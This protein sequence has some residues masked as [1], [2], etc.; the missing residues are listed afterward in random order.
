MTLASTTAQAGN[1][2]LFQVLLLLHIT[3]AV[4]G[5]GALVYRGLALDL[6]RRRG[7][8]PTAGV[9]DVYGQIS[10]IAEVLVYGVVVFGVAALA[11]SNHSSVFHRPWLPVAI[12]VYVVMLGVLHGM[13]RP[14]E[15]RYKELLLDLAQSP[16][17]APPNRPPELAQL[18][19]LSRRI[20]GG[21]GLFNVLLLA[22]LY[23][24]VFK[25]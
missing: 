22:A 11:A 10:G 2:V 5:F 20:G 4:G 7:P 3:C 8:A 21:M 17:V 18:D 24:M 1:S 9:L 19:R 13:V 12:G 15:K 6:A 16:S 14:A 23:L 25:P